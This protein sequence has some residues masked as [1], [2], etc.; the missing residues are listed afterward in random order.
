VAAPE[1]VTDVVGRLLDHAPPER[2][3]LHLHDTGGRALD[4]AMAGLDLGIPTFDSSAGGL[5]GCPFAPGA[6]GNLATGDLL[7]LL[8]ALGIEHGVDAA[9]VADA[10]AALTLTP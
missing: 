8:D 7:Q 10:V 5:G 3:A 9:A 6:P 2:L 1:Q 4:N